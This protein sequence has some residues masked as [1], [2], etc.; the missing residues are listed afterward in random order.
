MVLYVSELSN[1]DDRRKP[2]VLV[3]LSNITT[4]G[5]LQ[6]ASS[7]F[8][9]IGRIVDAPKRID[10]WPWLRD[11]CIEASLQV[12]ENATHHSPHMNVRK[13]AGT[14]AMRL[15]QRRS[16]PD[17]D[18][19][20]MLFGP[21]YAASR[22]RVEVVGFADVTTL[23]PEL[24]STRGVVSRLKHQIRRRVSRARFER[25]DVL[26]VEAPHVADELTSRWGLSPA[27]LRVVPNVLNSVFD[28]G[29]VE[30]IEV[31]PGPGKSFVYPTRLYPHKNLDVLGPAAESL[32]T[33][34]G[35]E[36]H[37]VLTL[38]PE[39]MARLSPAT[40]DVCV[41][42]GP[43]RASQMPGL[44]RACDAAVFTSLNEA[45]SVT[46]LEAMATGTPLVASDRAFVRDIAR[47][48][49]LYCDPLDP[50]SVADAL[51]VLLTEEADVRARRARGLEI[52]SNWPTAADRAEAY[53]DIIGTELQ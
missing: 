4:G 49:A 13:V 50:H 46:P 19:A 34:H 6:V 22:A 42:T 37:F 33:R 38:G 21:R 1:A 9:E 29:G 36:T 32:K 51:A 28:G 26:V 16:R 23:F 30:E 17:F 31:P 52:A 25:D 39:E 53:L 5:A 14:P 27:R 18:V 20:F 2:R 44:Y 15:R 24:A 12:L 48:A 11:A 8:D 3:D 35:L 10:R 7:L 40:R 47:D 41:T 45:F 43:L